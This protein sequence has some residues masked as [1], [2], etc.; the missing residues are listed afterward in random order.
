MHATTI[1]R[2][3]TSTLLT[4]LFAAALTPAIAAAPPVE[5]EPTLKAADFKGLPP[6]SGA[7][8]RIQPTVPVSGYQ[9]QF[10][11]K[12]D[13]GDVTADGTEQLRQRV[14]EVGAAAQLEK[15]STS[16]VFVKALAQSTA[17]S[18]EAIGKAVT[19]PVDTLKA[20]PAGL[21]RFFGSAK[22]TVSDT[23]SDGG[24]SVSDSMGVGKARRQI[25]HQVGVDPYSSNPL[26]SSRLDDL[27][28][29]A[30]AGGVSLDVAFAVATGGAAAA[31]S[32][33]KT[34]SN[35]AWELPP[36]D[37]RERNQKDLAAMKVDESTRKAL[38]NNSSYT[39]TLA[40]AFVDALKTLG[41]TEGADAF[42][43]LASDASSETEARFYIDQLRMA[44]AYGKQH[45][46]IES[47]DTAGQIGVMNAG[48]KRFVPMPVDYLSWTEGVKTAI[49]S[50]RFGTKEHIAWFTGELSPN[51]RKAFKEARWAVRENAPRA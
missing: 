15:M 6:L 46:R 45:G 30:F 16:D 13:L 25:A 42:A 29:A 20:V 8:Y 21:G 14:G 50:G 28:K 9:G 19:N 36:E 31:V 23:V 4:G 39:P 27:S 26:I 10:T 51:A 18:A 5:T 32:F 22:K 48:G 12:S 2:F 47:I 35:L 33:T 17:R 3:A 24:A 41:V 34:V 37:I 38:L 43:Q 1:V 49:E 11:V 40:L 44:S 7:G